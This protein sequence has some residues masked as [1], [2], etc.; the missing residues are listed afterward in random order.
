MNWKQFFVKS[1]LAFNRR[2]MS[3][4]W[5]SG[6]HKVLMCSLRLSQI[7]VIAVFFLETLSS[8][9]AFASHNPIGMHALHHSLV[10]LQTPLILCM[11]VC[12]P[13]VT[14]THTL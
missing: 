8:P 11:C 14:Q 10:Y 1:V 5:H 7:S 9:Y 13:I 2:L 6:R 3:L 12:A 4:Q